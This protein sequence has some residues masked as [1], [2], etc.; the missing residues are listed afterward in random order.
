MS[1]RELYDKALA[2]RDWSTLTQIRFDDESTETLL[3]EMYYALSAISM[4]MGRNRASSLDKSWLNEPMA[5]LHLR[6][7]E[8]Y[9]RADYTT[10]EI[11]E[12]AVHDLDAWE[13]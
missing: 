12:L 11:T 7:Q 6:F 3:L 13:G 5:E 10:D 8:I 2:D 9:R 4:E 1:L